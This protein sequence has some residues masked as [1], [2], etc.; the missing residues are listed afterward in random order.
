MLKFLLKYIELIN[1]AEKKQF[2][3]IQ[4]K[5]EF[6]LFL[7]QWKMCEKFGSFDSTGDWTMNPNDPYHVYLQLVSIGN[8]DGKRYLTCWIYL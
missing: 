3:E 5:N 4:I 6:P 2:N 7:R 8:F 1:M